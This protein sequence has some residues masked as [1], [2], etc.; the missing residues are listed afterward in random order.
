MIGTELHISAADGAG[1]LFW[2]KPGNGYGFPVMTNMRDRLAGE[3][4]RYL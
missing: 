4:A 1:T 2:D 3:D